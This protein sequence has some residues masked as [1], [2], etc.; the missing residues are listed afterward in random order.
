M[1]SNAK[2]EDGYLVLVY[3]QFLNNNTF[4]ANILKNY[5]EEGLE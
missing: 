3:L 5:F 4:S 2:I 1:K